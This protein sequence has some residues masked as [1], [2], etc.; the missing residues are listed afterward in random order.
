METKNI[1]EE[2]HNIL[3]VDKEYTI[4]PTL[5]EETFKELIKQRVDKSKIGNENVQP[6]LILDKDADN[7]LYLIYY[8]ENGKNLQI[9]DENIDYFGL[10]EGIRVKNSTFL[11]EFERTMKKKEIELAK[12]VKTR[13][14]ELFKKVE[15][16]EITL[17]EYANYSARLAKELLSTKTP[18]EYLEKILNNYR[19]KLGDRTYRMNCDIAKN[20]GVDKGPRKHK[21]PIR[22]SKEIDIEKRIEGIKNL[23]PNYEEIIIN[24]GEY[25]AYLYDLAQN[26]NAE[27]GC[28]IIVEPKEEIGNA[29]KVIYLS[30]EKL[31]ELKD[32]NHNKN[33]S[34]IELK[35]K[36]LK[37]ILEDPSKMNEIRKIKHGDYGKWLAIIDYYLKGTKTIDPKLLNIISDEKFKARY[38]REYLGAKR[39]ELMEEGR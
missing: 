27:N 4:I 18:E 28:M 15:S 34:D 35:A 7:N 24:D 20:D 12:V 21:R 17:N 13:Q 2:M 36:Y 31:R 6:R 14:D 32:N 5:L 30:K 1:I 39:K 8:D 25:Y 3:K 29:T 38:P 33:V 22:K 26:E 23:I 16:G 11:Y 37:E 9:L 10:D 19:E